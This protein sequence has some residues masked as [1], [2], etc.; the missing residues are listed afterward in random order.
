MILRLIGVSLKES[1]AT[2]RV[3]TRSVLYFKHAI[4]FNNS[5]SRLISM[6]L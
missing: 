4:F 5:W 3:R 6:S 1:A 2:A